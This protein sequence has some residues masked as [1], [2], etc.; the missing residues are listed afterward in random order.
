MMAVIVHYL[1]GAAVP[2]ISIASILN[3][4]GVILLVNRMRQL[5]WGVQQI[6]ADLKKAEIQIHR[7]LLVFHLGMEDRI[8]K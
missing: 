3:G 6:D 7:L 2:L 8:P 4:A 1:Y 5:Q